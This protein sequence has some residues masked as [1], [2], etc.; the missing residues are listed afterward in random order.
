MN[1]KDWIQTTL[2]LIGIISLIIAVVTLGSHLALDTDIAG[3]RT[4]I[5]ASE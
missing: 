1:I 4:E 3:L 5:R 2:Y